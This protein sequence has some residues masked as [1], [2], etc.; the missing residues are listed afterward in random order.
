[1]L[2]EQKLLNTFKKSKN[3]TRE[4][5]KR[6]INKLHKTMT[7][8]RGFELSKN[9]DTAYLLDDYGYGNNCYYKFTRRPTDK[10][11][12]VR[13]MKILNRIPGLTREELVAVS[14]KVKNLKTGNNGLIAS[15]KK[16]GLIQTNHRLYY[17]TDL[18]NNYLKHFNL[19]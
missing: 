5:Y 10:M 14:G 8:R 3:K 6:F 4:S 13:M 16:A 7:E 11:V 12:Y 19:I 18:G 9:I 1:M 15:M 2:K 17:I